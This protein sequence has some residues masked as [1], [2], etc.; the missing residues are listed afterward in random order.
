MFCHI[1]GSHFGVSSSFCRKCGIKKRQLFSLPKEATEKESICHYFQR[2]FSYQ[3][4]V[5]ILKKYHG[6]CISVRTVKRRL[7]DYGLKRRKCENRENVVR[8]II[9]QEITG[10]S[11]LI[12]YRS[13][14]NRLRISY[15]INVPRN[16]VMKLLKEID[17]QGTQF[18]K[19]RTLKRR[20]YHS[21]GKMSSHFL[22]IFNPVR[23]ATWISSNNYSFSVLC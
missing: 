1:C 17:P 22:S 16:R 11:S 6:I 10:P 5:S 7:H 3:S 9:D 14:W 18:R 12:G 21:P 4:I 23:F 19:R 20:E 15:G 2:N 8:S 13:M